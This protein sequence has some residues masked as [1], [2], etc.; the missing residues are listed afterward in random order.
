MTALA[1][2]LVVLSLVLDVSGQVMFKL[3]L[4]KLEAQG[5]DA[6]AHFWLAVARSPW[7]IGGVAAYAVEIP[8]WTA[9]LGLLPLN[10]A[11]PLA[12]LSYCG[13]AIAAYFVL[14]EKVPLRRWLATAL[15]AAGVAVVAGSV[16][17]A[18]VG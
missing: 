8:L 7:L 9:V 2:I 1:I 11:F 12:C 5:I 4:N 6:G 3:G 18:G 14:G 17:A 13:V 10:V 16:S 15:I